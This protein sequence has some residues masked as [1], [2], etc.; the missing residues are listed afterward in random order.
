MTV[1]AFLGIFAL[2]FILEL[3]DKTM[4]A[5]VV[6][7]TRARPRSI[8][9]G[10][11][12]AF[13]VQCA[14]AV[15]VGG[16]IALLPF[17]LKDGVVATLFLAGAAYL[18]FVKEKTEEEKGEREGRLEYSS[19][20]LREIVTAFN[21]VFIG[22]FGDLTQIQAANLSAKTHQPVEVWLAG[23]LAC[24]GDGD[25]GLRRSDAPARG[26]AWTH[27]P[28]RWSHLLGPRYLHRRAIG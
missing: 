27:P 1:G 2:M 16:L 7:D 26:A 21:V 12:A 25:R 10:A 8:V 4:I 11:S 17:R 23:S 19:T 24:P 13:L 14:L 28:T 5:M 20:R 15:T 3:P 18:L 6:M 22:Q 9:I